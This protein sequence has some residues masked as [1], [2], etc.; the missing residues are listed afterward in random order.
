MKLVKIDAVVVLTARETTTA[1]VLAVLACGRGGG[2]GAG[3]RRRER[4]AGVSRDRKEGRQRTDATVAHA[5][6][7][8]HL[9]RLLQVGH[10]LEI[11]E[12]RAE[13]ATGEICVG[14]SQ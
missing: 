12:G 14:D 3:G 4:R 8:A 9:A 11:V 5:N 2:R 7:A 10:H 1:C 13:D 6:L